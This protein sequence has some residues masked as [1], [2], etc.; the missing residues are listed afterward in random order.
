MFPKSIMSLPQPKEAF[1]I[2]YISTVDAQLFMYG[3]YFIKSSSCRPSDGNI[4]F[5]CTRSSY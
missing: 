2:V 4:P 1:Y 5:L 3:F